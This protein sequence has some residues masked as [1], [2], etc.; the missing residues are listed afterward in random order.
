M[1]DHPE[2]RE[3]L[4]TIENIESIIKKSPFICNIVSSDTK[5]VIDILGLNK[6]ISSSSIICTVDGKFESFWDYIY[7]NPQNIPYE[8]RL[9]MYM[10]YYLIY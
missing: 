3:W 6:K 5:S 7:N 9:A 10:P 4:N 1:E 8:E 2:L